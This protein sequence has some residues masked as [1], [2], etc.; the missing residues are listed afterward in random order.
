MW[1]DRM[2]QPQGDPWLL[3]WDLGKTDFMEP[4]LPPAFLY[5]NPWPK[6]KRVTVAISD[7]ENRLY[8]LTRKKP[9]PTHAGA[10]ELTLSPFEAR[11]V[12]IR[13]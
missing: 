12:E 9:V 10:A 3:R 11:V 5:Y 4:D 8:D 7:K 1:L 2:M 13:K 6:P